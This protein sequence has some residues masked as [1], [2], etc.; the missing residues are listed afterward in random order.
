[1]A[2]LNNLTIKT[3]LFLNLAMIFLALATLV[4]LG[5]QTANTSAREAERLIQTD[6]QLGEPLRFFNQ[7]FIETLQLSN[8]YTLT[9]D[10]N[11][12]QN[13]NLKV[14]EQIAALA[15]LLNELGAELDY[16]EGGSLLILDIHNEENLDFINTLY[17]L[18]RILRNLKNAT[19]SSV[20]M[21]QRILQTLDFGIQASSLSLR[22]ALDE[23]NRYNQTAANAELASILASLRERLVLSQR[24]TAEMIAAKNPEIKSQF[25]EIGLGFAARPLVQSVQ[26]ALRG[27]FFNRQLASQLDE[28]WGNYFDAFGDIR[29]TLI[30]Q[31]QNNHSLAELSG[32]GNDI[33]VTTSAL[34]QAANT[35]SLQQQAQEADTMANQLVI[36]SSLA[37]LVLLLVNLLISRSIV[38]PIDQL[39]KQLLNLNETSNFSTMSSLTGRNEL[40]EMQQ[41]M[42]TLLTQVTDA[43]N[44]ITQVSQNL[45]QGQTSQRMSGDYR[46]DLAK[47]ATEMNASLANIEQT[48]NQVETAAQALAGGDYKLSIDSQNQQ[49]RFL[50]V[51][52]AI[53]DAMNIQNQAIEDI[54]HVTHA[55]REGDFSQRVTL[56]MPGDLANLK[57]YLNE[58]LDRL[59]E[60]LDAKSA[61]L[62]AF[63]QGDFSHQSEAVFNGKLHELNQH[64]MRMA[65]SISQML[66]EVRD[67]S[68]HAAH[69]IHEISSGN[70]DLNDRVQKQA[71]ALQQTTQSMLDMVVDVNQTMA[72]AQDVSQ[73]TEQ[74]F[75][76]STTGSATV[77]E[78]VNAMTAI[79]E[80]SHDISALTDAIDSVAF[81]TNLLALNASVEAARAG[82]AGRGFAVVASEVRNLAQR[83]A[84]VSKQIRQASNMNIE[85]IGKGM[86]LSHQTQQIFADTLARVQKIN[87]KIGKMNT[88]LNR[89]NEGIQEVND[90]LSAID[91][92]TQQNA[93]LVEQIASTSAN[94]IHE[95]TRLEQ[96]VSQFR[97]IEPSKRHA[98]PAS[99]KANLVQLPAA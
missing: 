5:W 99:N 2:F 27:D 9:G 69:G 66:T 3:R 45:A 50:I 63:S 55:M 89:Q 29:D 34:L 90:A 97:L 21:E 46:G 71:A 48:L 83:T 62:E 24:L 85:R 47:L 91:H 30:T 42:M 86:T 73:S 49:G 67:A 8:A 10:A 60:A 93:A 84:E 20:F 41:A 16:D 28:A 25:D 54:R 40:V 22:N 68:D 39:K 57:R 43:F 18:D 44:Q 59:A 15:G 56:K 58:S 26:D 37:A 51:T 13:F 72:D 81:Q 70:Q 79:Q 36:I 4:L 17:G 94:I 98:L 82:E 80:A 96:K 65:Q 53:K 1:M 52:Q 11:T 87:T 88:A 14:D 31:V 95:V 92:T 32:Q 64:M 78:M 61:A 74:M 7:N 75:Q 38:S 77:S 35:T 23:L 33:L 12:G 19:N 6:L 76:A